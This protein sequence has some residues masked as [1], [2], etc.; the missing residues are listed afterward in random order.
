MYNTIIRTGP[1]FK[2]WIKDGASRCRMIF[3]KECEQIQQTKKKPN[4]QALEFLTS[5]PDQRV[6]EI[7]ETA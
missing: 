4:Y 5:R 7:I 2:G 6:L 1:C 3:F